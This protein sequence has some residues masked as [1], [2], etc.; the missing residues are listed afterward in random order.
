MHAPECP[1]KLHI[2]HNAD[3][4]TTNACWWYN[5][6]YRLERQRGYPDREDLWTPGVLE[7]S[8]TPNHPVGFIASTRPIPW[9]NADELI[10]H[11]QSRYER[12]AATF[13]KTDPKDDFLA[14][15]AQAA[16][17]FVVRRAADSSKTHTSVNGGG[18]TGGS[19]GGAST[20]CVGAAVIAGYPW[21]EY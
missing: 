20:I 19:G 4:F 7:F 9:S 21:F 3:R 11:T 8:L 6:T 15:L 10:R 18:A 5:F 14:S 13:H 12:L 17:Q 2:P 16:D 1:V